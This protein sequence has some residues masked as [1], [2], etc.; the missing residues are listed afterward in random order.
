MIRNIRARWKDIP[1]SSGAVS[2]GLEVVSRWCK[3]YLQPRKATEWD[4]SSRIPVKVHEKYPADVGDPDGFS[5]S[6]VFFIW[7]D[8]SRQ[9]HLGFAGM[10]TQGD[11]SGNF[12]I[13]PAETIRTV[14]NGILID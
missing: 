4:L 2:E 13:Y 12:Q 11:K 1:D 3:L 9:T 14:V 8:E 5:G 6:P 7:Q 10:I